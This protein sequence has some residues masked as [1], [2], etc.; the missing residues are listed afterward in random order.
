MC[1]YWLAQ[2]G[3]AACLP[4]RVTLPVACSI[5]RVRVPLHSHQTSTME[6]PDFYRG[7][8]VLVTGATGFIGKALVEKLLRHCPHI[9]CVF[10]L[11]RAKRGVSPQE[12]LAKML[13]LPVS[14]K[15][16]AISIQ[17]RPLGI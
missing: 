17:L 7:R 3:S 12:R 15:R 10:V 13:A 16:R 8:S 1:R 2:H 14:T 6:I 4:A 5:Q 11:V 9:E